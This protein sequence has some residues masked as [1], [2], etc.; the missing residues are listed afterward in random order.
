MNIN[1]SGPENFDPT[2]IWRSDEFAQNSG[3]SNYRCT[4]CSRGFSN[5]QALGGH[6]NIHRKDRAKLKEFPNEISLTLDLIGNSS[7]GEKL[8]LEKIDD[9]RNIEV[10]SS[11][12]EN[13]KIRLPLFAEAPTVSGGGE[14]ADGGSGRFEKDLKKSKMELIDAEVDLELR[15]GPEPHFNAK[16]KR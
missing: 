16:T 4:F 15:L 10:V 13:S 14:A 1:P 7:T 2:I 3:R 6:M 8:S 12:K 5:A 11:Y 9:F